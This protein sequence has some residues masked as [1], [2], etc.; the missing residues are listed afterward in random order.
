M[1]WKF[2]GQ[3]TILDNCLSPSTTYLIEIKR[4]WADLTANIFPSEAYTSS[5]L[6]IVHHLTGIS[7]NI[8][9]F[10][11]KMFF[12]LRESFPLLLAFLLGGYAVLKSH[13]SL[14]GGRRM[15]DKWSLILTQS[16]Q[17]ILSYL[18]GERHLVMHKVTSSYAFTIKVKT[19]LWWRQYSNKVFLTQAHVHTSPPDYAEANHALEE[20]FFSG[21]ELQFVY[22]FVFTFTLYFSLERHP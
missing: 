22:V 2:G 6:G 13:S 19:L 7:L 1:W 5:K 17:L 9:C 21:C 3:R 4:R 12:M 14:H 8:C 11:I 20:F 10:W 15:S 16:R 18:A